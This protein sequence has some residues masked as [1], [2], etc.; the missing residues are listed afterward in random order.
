MHMKTKFLV[1][2]IRN[3]GEF[4]DLE[5]E[6][7][8]L[9]YRSRASSIFLTWEWIRSWR[10][11]TRDAVEPYCIA[12]RNINGELVGIAPLYKTSMK[13]LGVLPYRML[14][15]M[16]DVATG[17]EYPD[18]I[19]EKGLE[20][21]VGDAI[22]RELRINSNEWDTVWLPRMSGWTG[23]FER[24]GIAAL[25]SGLLVHERAAKFGALDLGPS[26]EK[27]ELALSRSGRQQ[28]RRNSRK[29]RNIDGVEFCKCSR[30]DEL[31]DYLTAFFELHQIR[32]ESAGL[33][34]TFACKSAEEAFYRHFVPVAFRNGW[35]SIYGLRYH[36]EFKAVQLGYVFDA[37]YYQMQEGYD[38]DFA[39]GA[40]NALRHFAIEDCIDTGVHSYDFLGGWTEHKRRWGARLR[41]GH[42]V[43]LGSPKLKCRALFFRE[44]WP[45]GRYVKELTRP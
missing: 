25:R 21:L 13:F 5:Q 24:I 32:W 9:L 34:G 7:N 37:T 43:F 22:M 3:W 4:E 18:W 16:A 14:R 20:D 41:F 15:F 27:Y 30:S 10:A 40:G 26:L 28:V 39:Q 12:V 42:E 44:I 36:D 35:L 17:F 19:V 11:A 8:S 6:W 38:P 23:A 1:Q 31:D 45:S 2:V 29:I 33:D